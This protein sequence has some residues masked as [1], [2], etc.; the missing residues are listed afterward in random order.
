MLNLNVETEKI[1]VSE[2]NNMVNI[3]Q[4]IQIKDKF[5][6]PYSNNLNTISSCSQIMQ[7]I[8]GQASAKKKKADSQRV[9][10][11]D[12]SAK[13][14]GSGTSIE[15]DT[16]I[17]CRAKYNNKNKTLMICKKASSN[18]SNNKTK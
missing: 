16:Y 14:Q 18:H 5:R 6:M 10:K 1:L 11:D 3:G 17:S 8:E 12:G 4:I 13:S 2:M 7:Q 9:I 15:R